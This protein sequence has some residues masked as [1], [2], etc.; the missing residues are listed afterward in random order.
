V[1]ILAFD[2]ASRATAV[3]LAAP[4]GV[5]ER[6]DDPPSGERPGHATR[7]LPL[8]STVMSEA[9]LEWPEIDRI[10]VGLGPG[11]FTGL[12]IGVATAKAL[13]QAS[14]AALV[15]VSTLQALALAAPETEHDAV[16]GVLDARRGEVYAG[17]WSPRDVP[18]PA[19]L[20]PRALGPEA[21][22]E[23]LPGLGSRPLAVGEGAVAFRDV[24]ER[25][26]V[27]V[28][29]QGSELH[30]VTAVSHCRLA[31]YLPVTSPDSLTPDYQRLPDAKP[32][33]VP[34]TPDRPRGD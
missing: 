19:L 8:I 25:A 33:S 26:G 4:G 34:A 31:R 30:R 21:L 20:T 23:A 12:R 14:G 10:A 24:L 18:G 1:R 5:W 7:L 16:L 15:G 13:S 27:D 22:R 6:R 28:P 9:G 11:T 29:S 2:T 32:R 3:A 17:A